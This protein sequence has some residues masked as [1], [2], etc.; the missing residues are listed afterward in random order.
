MYFI[1]MAIL[2]RE[3][4]GKEVMVTTRPLPPRYFLMMLFNASNSVLICMTKNIGHSFLGKG[5]SSLSLE[6]N[7]FHLER[8][9]FVANAKPPSVVNL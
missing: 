2:I 9:S 4:R 5:N 1:R 8:S 6:E 7:S 3:L